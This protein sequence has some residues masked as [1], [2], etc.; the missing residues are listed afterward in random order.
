MTYT[1]TLAG[2]G[3]VAMG[4][5]L[6]V[7]DPG[8][9]LTHA[10]AFSQHP[11]FRLVGGADPSDER[12]ALFAEHYGSAAGP[13]LTAVLA[14]EN[15]DVV[16]IAA[17]TPLHAEL[18]RTTFAH[19]QPRAILCEKPLS[20]DLEAARAMVRTCKA[21]GCAL[22]V[23][24]MR[25]AAA[26][27]REVKRRFEQGEIRT[28]LR[29]VAWYT[30]GL[31]HNGSHF[32]DLLAHW[33]G[34]VSGFEVLRAGRWWDD[35]DPEPDVR[36]DFA[37]G[38]VI[39]LAAREEDYSFCEIDLIAPNGRVRC[40]GGGARIFW[41][42][43]VADPLYPRYTVLSD[44]VEEIPSGSSTMQGEVAGQLAAALEGRPVDLCSGAEALVTLEWLMKVRASL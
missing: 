4:Y 20:Y 34:P 2:L 10:R 14:R 5:D 17:P 22:Y 44:A 23:N 1:V 40:I 37:S 8:T 38:S 18:L 41:Y 31:I 13:S 32:V 21:R 7:S 30:K 6:N 19:A 29:G 36:F 11:E 3:Q 27:V 24:Y 25:R 26:G 9:I 16:V 12:R 28:P 15:P 35:D 39:F 43:A 33:L 42:A